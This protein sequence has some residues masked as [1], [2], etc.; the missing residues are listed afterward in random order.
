[1]ITIP[2]HEPIGPSKVS[3]LSLQQYH[4][5]EHLL[6]YFDWVLQFYVFQNF[7]NFD[8]FNSNW[9]VY[10]EPEK[11][12]Q[13]NFLDFAKIGQPI[14]DGFLIHRWDPQIAQDQGTG[15]GEAFKESKILDGGDRIVGRLE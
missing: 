8:F 15:T 3:L 11:P 6:T 5:H 1:V 7:S 4:S 14:F 13:T 12:V 10:G 9:P 2:C